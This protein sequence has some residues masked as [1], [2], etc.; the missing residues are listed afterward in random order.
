MKGVYTVLRLTKRSRRFL[1]KATGVDLPVGKSRIDASCR[2][3]GPCMVGG[4]VNL[5]TQI[6]VGAFTTFDGDRGD[7]RIRN[8]SIGRYCAIAKHVDIGLSRH[9][10]TWLGVSARQYFPKYG[11]WHGFL[12]KTVSCRPFQEASFTEIGNDV[13][14]G[15]RV[16]VMAGVKI[17]DG[18]IVGA[19]AV[20]TKDVPPYAIVGGVPARIISYRF[21]ESVIRELLELKWWRYDISDFGDVDWSDIRVAIT[22]IKAKMS[23]GLTPYEPAPVT[24]RML[25]PYAFRH[26]FH[27]EISRRF[28]RIKFFGVWIV[29]RVRR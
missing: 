25:R 14:I 1:F 18:A 13:W 15:D 5:K 11:N 4:S 16:V 12:G 8:L 20:V 26:W 28:I 24:C 19:G 3:E 22:E 7:C 2:F 27:F 9:P 23:S 17:G 10:T 29:H 6:R 21:D